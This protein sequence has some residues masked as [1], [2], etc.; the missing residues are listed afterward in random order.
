M[1]NADRVGHTV[2]EPEGAAFAA[3]AARWPSV[4]V[5]GRIDRA[6][7]A[8]IVFSEPNELAELEAMTHPAIVAEIGS[9]ADEAPGSVVLEVPVMLPV[10]GTWHRVFVDADEA[11]RIDRAVE[12]GGDPDD[13]R[14]RAAVQAEREAWVAWADEVIVN[15]GSEEALRE[16]VDALWESLSPPGGGSPDH[17]P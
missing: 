13:V 8:V 14:R 1:I 3:V 2:L 17:G 5:D 6:S 12:R 10:G 9:L 7:L 16:R 11:L 15:D 4:V